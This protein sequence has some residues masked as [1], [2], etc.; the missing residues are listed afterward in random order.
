MYA[1]IHETGPDFSAGCALPVTAERF[2]V[3]HPYPLP[4]EGTL[5][6]PSH[7]REWLDASTVS[8]H[9]HRSESSFTAL[10]LV[11]WQQAPGR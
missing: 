9:S 7:P 3:T 4:S 11:P 8:D 5:E 6:S 1:Y 10:T 2:L